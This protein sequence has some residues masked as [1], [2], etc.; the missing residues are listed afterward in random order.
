M[1]C[2]QVSNKLG[3]EPILTYYLLEILAK[4]G[5]MDKQGN[6]IKIQGQLKFF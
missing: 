1:S 6:F 4:L 2:E 3:V 5:L